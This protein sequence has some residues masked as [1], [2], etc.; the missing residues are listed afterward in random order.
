MKV[1]LSWFNYNEDFLSP[2]SSEEFFV[3]IGDIFQQG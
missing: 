3:D 2:Y 1:E